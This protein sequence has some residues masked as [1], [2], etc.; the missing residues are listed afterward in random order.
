MSAEEAVDLTSPEVTGESR[1]A[2]HLPSLVVDE[3]PTEMKTVRVARLPP[4]AREEAVMSTSQAQILLP[5]SW[6]DVVDSDEEEDS[7]GAGRDG[8]ALITGQRIRVTGTDTNKRGR[9]PDQSLAE[10]RRSE[11]RRRMDATDTR[12]FQG[13][14]R[15]T[16]V[17]SPMSEDAYEAY[18][19]CR[20]A[21][22]RRVGTA[23]RAMVAS[24]LE[25]RDTNIQDA[26][27]PAFIRAYLRVGREDDLLR[28]CRN[29]WKRFSYLA[30]PSRLIFESERTQEGGP[31]P[32]VTEC[33]IPGTGETE[34][35]G[36]HP[37]LTDPERRLQRAVVEF[38][39]APR[40]ENDDAGR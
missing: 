18:E 22:L 23:D 19:E 10:R 16:T 36:E 11:S 35:A 32:A 37:A 15:D 12:T 20:R 21:L 34:H 4:R 13:V 6:A 25:E 9:G 26:A 2:E 3:S 5:E 30:L 8:K 38:G 39:S 17:T 1:Q 27:A 33:L 24:L 14:Q 31:D 28:L 40:L 29:V 7:T